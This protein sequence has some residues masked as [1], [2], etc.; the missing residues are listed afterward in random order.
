VSAETQ[1]LDEV[2][3]KDFLLLLLREEKKLWNNHKINC[4]ESHSIQFSSTLAS[5]LRVSERG[6]AS[7]WVRKNGGIIINIQT[8]AL[9]RLSTMWWFGKK[10]DQRDVIRYSPWTMVNDIINQ[11]SWIDF[12]F[13]AA[14]WMMWW[15]VESVFTH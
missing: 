5:S 3:N 8:N 12:G 14:R 9:K 6:R 11:L 15:D 2:F 1:S 7:E 4:V 10:D 13:G